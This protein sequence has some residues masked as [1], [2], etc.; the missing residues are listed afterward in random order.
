MIPFPNINPNLIEIGPLKLR[1]YGVM[2]VLAFALS[3]FLIAGQRRAR[4][5]GLYGERLQNLIFALAIGLIV[6][7]RFGYILFYQ[8][9]NLSYYLQAPLEIIA[10]WHG[11]MSFHGGLIGAV[12]AGVIF[13]RRRGLPFWEAADTVFVAAPVGLGLGRLGNFINGELFGRPASVPWAMVFPA[14]GS[15]PRH[16]SQLYEALL[17]GALLFIILWKSKDLN[18]RPGTMVCFFLGGYGLMRFIT[19]FFRQPDPQLGLIW[20]M[21][22]MGQILCLSMILMSIFLWIFL[23]PP[24]SKH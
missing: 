7:A 12:F 3:Y 17:E 23:R 9:G 11:G 10:V 14:G 16:P 21:V 6:G 1:W 15:V 4:K 5:L 24:L 13:C 22:S 18:L 20:G 8:F 19:E 2:Y